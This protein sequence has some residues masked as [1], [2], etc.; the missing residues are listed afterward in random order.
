MPAC[1]AK[2]VVVKTGRLSVFKSTSI[3]ITTERKAL[4]VWCFNVDNSKNIVGPS[5]SGLLVVIHIPTPVIM[6]MKLKIDCY[7]SLHLYTMP[8]YQ[9]GK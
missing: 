9:P 5:L 8:G 4:F 7:G 2:R 1:K 3:K 6:A